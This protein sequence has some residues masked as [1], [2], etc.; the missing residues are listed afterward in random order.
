MKIDVHVHTKKCKSGDAATR[1]VSPSRFCEIVLA[2]DVKIIA[3]T[4]HNAFDLEQ[5]NNII[6]AIDKEVQVWPGI[7][8]DIK[9]GEN[10][11]HLLV[12]VSPSK[13]EE[14]SKIIG[15]ITAGSDPDSFITS[16]Q[17][18]VTKFDPLGPLYIAHYQQKKPDISDVALEK[19]ISTTSNRSRVIK[20]VTNSIS[21]GIY[22]S[23]GYPSI[24]GS[25]IHDWDQY[26]TESDKL[27]DLRLPVE[28]FEHFCLLLDKDPT[29]INTLLDKKTSEVL[30][31]K[32]FD[33][34]TEV[35]LK[36]F[37]DIN[38]LFGAKGTGKSCI[39]QAI[40]KHFCD[41]GMD[42]K[43]FESGND[44]LEDKYDLR[45]RDLTI[46][47]A[48]FGINYCTDEINF[49]K[50]AREVDVTNVSNYYSFFASE[51][52]NRNA[53]KIL[54][55]DFDSEDESGPKRKFEDYNESTS[56]IK[57]FLDFLSKSEP[58]S[59]VFSHED[60]D[61]LIKSIN[62]LF[63]GL[64]QGKWTKFAKWKEVHL[65]NSAI[66]TYKKEVTRKTGSPAKPTTTGFRDYA[67]NRIKIEANA[68]EVLV[69]IKKPI[70]EKIEYVGN[71]GVDKGELQ[72]K[73]IM[74]IHDGN[75]RDGTLNTVK[76]IKKSTQKFFV[77][78]IQ[79]IVS[80]VYGEK[81]FETITALNN[82]PD[83]EDIKTINELLLFK[84]HFS[85]NDNDYRPSTGES[86]ML[87]LQNELGTEKDVYILDEP[88]KSLG[89]E[90][91]ND[92]IVPILKEKARAGKKVFISTHDANIA[93]RTLP[94]SS[95][96]RCHGRHGYDTYVGNP[97][98][99]HLIN[100]RDNGDKL[101]WKK[102]SMKT[103]EGGEEAFGE[104]GKIYGNT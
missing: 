28:S 96:Y 67:L 5:F 60:L 29:T 37:S 93:V 14:F 91:I 97:F 73:T 26:E 52:R 89:N 69:N 55:K 47:L 99:N 88:E 103:L 53:K 9:D 64:S 39:L 46:N 54:I 90:Y 57:A 65:L 102:V 100:I 8:L 81:L 6:N 33:D 38:V 61:G 27:P 76:G 82:I 16:I 79:D 98:S 32:P 42:A 2:T 78:T 49:V 30:A 40:A 71:L 84:R 34:G 85:I 4:N 77:Q 68:K 24:Y 75:V 12:I 70:S 86:S 58:V 20:E 104:R 1:E 56:K 7:E 21:A 17:E 44:S 87:M 15:S 94:Y 41:N 59:K 19:L 35:K 63:N 101:D 25:D 80:K 51:H 48:P 62:R 92:V 31:L 10:R 50:N 18:T 13:S 22:I 36:I 74:F 11:G 72:C 3:I 23:H 45:G 83:I 66:K 95:V 43:V